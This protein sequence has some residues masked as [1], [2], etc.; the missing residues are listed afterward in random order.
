G[1]TFVRPAAHPEMQTED[2]AIAFENGGLILMEC[3]TVECE[4]RRAWE[5]FTNRDH[6]TEK[7]RD[8]IFRNGYVVRNDGNIVDSDGAPY[9]G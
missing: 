7:Q 1:W 2:A 3:P 5:Q 6:I 9:T 8:V 4:L